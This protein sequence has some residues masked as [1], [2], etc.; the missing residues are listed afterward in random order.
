[1][2]EYSFFFCVCVG[3]VF[4]L[5]EKRQ[6]AELLRI[7]QTVVIVADSF[8]LEECLHSPLEDTLIRE[9]P[10]KH[11]KMKALTLSERNTTLYMR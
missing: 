8:A 2:F 7:R 11:I 5:L 4:S 9:I 3:G 1:M 10:K 6:T